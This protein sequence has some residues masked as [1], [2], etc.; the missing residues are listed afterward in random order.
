MDSLTDLMNRLDELG[1]ALAAAAQI[2][3]DALR[4]EMLL[5]LQQDIARI[6]QLAKA[7]R[8]EAAGRP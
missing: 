7:A 6:Y 2:A 5:T 4:T 8:D 3:D 1:D